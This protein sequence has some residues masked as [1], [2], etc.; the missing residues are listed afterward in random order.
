MRR[1]EQRLQIVTEQK[2]TTSMIIDEEKKQILAIARQLTAPEVEPEMGRN[3]FEQMRCLRSFLILLI[4][5]E[6]AVILSFKGWKGTF[7]INPV[8]QIHSAPV[9]PSFLNTNCLLEV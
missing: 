4:N 5:F 6:R 1:V 8:L 3:P 7:L 2:P 9:V